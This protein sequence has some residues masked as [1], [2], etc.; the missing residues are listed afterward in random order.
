MAAAC[1]VLM[2]Y[3]CPHRRTG[4]GSKPIEL[5][6]GGLQSIWLWALV[7]TVAIAAALP[8]T[9]GL[10]M[11][12]V[13]HVHL[14]WTNKTT[15]EYHEGVTAQIRAAAGAGGQYQH[16]YDIGPCGNIHEVLGQVATSWVM[17]DWEGTSGGTKYPTM[18]DRPDSRQG[19]SDLGFS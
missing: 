16:P 19:S 15:I 1:Q 7:Q 12:L 17:P 8:I 6:Q 13:W 9:I 10:V 18:F 11:L 4:P 2:C 14:V 5:Q 3:C